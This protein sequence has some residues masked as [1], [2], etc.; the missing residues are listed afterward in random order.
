LHPTVLALR[1]SAGAWG[2]HIDHHRRSG[3][4]C[5]H[6]APQKRGTSS[7]NRLHASL[8]LFRAALCMHWSDR[9]P[10]RQGAAFKIDR[11]GRREG[12]ANAAGAAGTSR[13]ARDNP[14]P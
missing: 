8:R 6:N 9:Q 10:W 5:T 4:T 14:Q 11:K 13:E 12:K 3:R 7:V 1:P 2:G